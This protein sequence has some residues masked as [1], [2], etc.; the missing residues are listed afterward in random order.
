MATHNINDILKEIPLYKHKVE[1]QVKFH[2]VDS[3]GVLH[4][5]QYFY[6]LEWARTQ[7]FQY[8]G[9]P[10]NSRTFTLENPVMTVNHELNYYYPAMFTDE[11]EVFTRITEVKNSSMKFENI[12]LHA[13]GNVMA[14]ASAILVY[15][16]VE[17]YIPVRIP[18]DLREKIKNFE[19]DN[20]KFIEK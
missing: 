11:Y 5:I 4:N 18:D 14:K 16:N 2:E 7:Y 12:I 6:I 9:M 10:V 15:M 8:I 13:N 19:N 1:G 17:D 3:F 20:V